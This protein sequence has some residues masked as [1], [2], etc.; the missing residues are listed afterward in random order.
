MNVYLYTLDVR[1][2]GGGDVLELMEGLR[3]FNPDVLTLDFIDEFINFTA[4]GDGLDKIAIEKFLG[5][6][7]DLKWEYEEED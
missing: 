7:T 3:D 4:H 6:F 5:E 1:K 2:L